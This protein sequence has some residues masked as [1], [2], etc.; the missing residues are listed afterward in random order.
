M[1]IAPAPTTLEEAINAT[2]PQLF[3]LAATGNLQLGYGLWV[4]A[5]P[6][7]VDDSPN[8][9]TVR[10]WL[11]FNREL[12]P[13]VTASGDA[14]LVAD[15]EE[16]VTRVL[17]AAVGARDAGRITAGQAGQFVTDWINSLNFI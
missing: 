12:L 14:Q 11:V 6:P 1:A 15:V 2:A 10:D 17:W 3:T 13:R 5:W 16:Q 7:N 9:R 8:G 4:N